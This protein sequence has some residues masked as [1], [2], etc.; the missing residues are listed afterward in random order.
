[1]SDC[2]TVHAFPLA[3]ENSWCS[4]RKKA[5]Q[6]PNR[7]GTFVVYDEPDRTDA[8]LEYAKKLVGQQ[9]CDLCNT[10]TEPG[11]SICWDCVES[12]SRG[13]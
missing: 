1:M 7:R 3:C 6:D 2:K 8:V 13:E 10:N 5:E 4:Q 12:V 11:E 9:T